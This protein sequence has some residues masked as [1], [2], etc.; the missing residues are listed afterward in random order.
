MMNTM[1]DVIAE[2]IELVEQAAELNPSQEVNRHLTK[3]LRS[4]EAAL[5]AHNIDESE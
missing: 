1:S 2:A 3:A 4:L 5:Q